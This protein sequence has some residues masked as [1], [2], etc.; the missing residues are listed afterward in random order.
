MI[1][2]HEGTGLNLQL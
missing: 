2:K 1:A